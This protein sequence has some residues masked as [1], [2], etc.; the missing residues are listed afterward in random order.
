M[1]LMLLW[2][3]HK[4]LMIGLICVSGILNLIPA[5]VNWPLV[6]AE[7]PQA[8]DPS[9]NLPRQHMASWNGF[10]LGIQGKPLPAGPQIANDPTRSAGRKFPDLWTVRLMETSRLGMVVGLAISLVLVLST[11]WCLRELLRHP[12]EAKERAKALAA[13]VSTGEW[14]MRQRCA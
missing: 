7:F 10:L 3:E 11:A 5:V 13:L 14:Q 2:N 9:A 12:P 6:V 1:I 4:K 8:A